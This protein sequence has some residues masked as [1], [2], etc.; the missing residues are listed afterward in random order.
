MCGAIP[1]RDLKIVNVLKNTIE[2]SDTE[3]LEVQWPKGSTVQQNRLCRD[4]EAK[5]LIRFCR[6][7]F[8]PNA[9]E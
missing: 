6:D 2:R 1:D 7:G 5:Q 8:E 3:S 9:F 4:G